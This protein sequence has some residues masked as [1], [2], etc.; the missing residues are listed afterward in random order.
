MVVKRIWIAM[1]QS[2]LLLNWKNRNN[3]LLQGGNMNF[4]Q[5]DFCKES[6]EILYRV[7]LKHVYYCICICTCTWMCMFSKCLYNFYL[8]TFKGI[9]L[10]F[11]KIFNCTHRTYSSIYI[12]TKFRK[13]CRQLEVSD[14]E[15]SINRIS[16]NHKMSFKKECSETKMFIIKY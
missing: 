5:T 11:S 7:T 10:S 14:D 4:L 15:T 9:Y 1:R 3:S 16:H 12:R 2:I 6:T 13:K 8:A